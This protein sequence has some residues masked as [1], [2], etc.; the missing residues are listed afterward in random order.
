[1]IKLKNNTNNF[2]EYIFTYL[3]LLYIRVKNNKKIQK[4]ENE[5][6][7]Y[8]TGEYHIIEEEL[9]KLEE[10]IKIKFSK[11]KALE[12]YKQYPILKKQVDIFV[13]NIK[14]YTKKF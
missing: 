14:N 1:M 4:V 6:F 9:E 3:I 5:S 11:E 13:S 2:H 8:N 10:N 12:L 7:L